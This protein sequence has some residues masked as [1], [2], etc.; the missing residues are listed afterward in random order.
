MI[1]YLLIVIMI[2]YG[3]FSED[4]HTRFV[5]RVIAYSYGCS[6]LIQTVWDAPLMLWASFFIF[7]LGILYAVV[8][9]R[10]FISRISFS[11][12]AFCISFN[13]TAL[14]LQDFSIIEYFPFYAEYSHKIIRESI[15]AGI[16]SFAIWEKGNKLGDAKLWLSVLW[17]MGVEYIYYN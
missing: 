1:P 16:A 15:L 8:R 2:M 12:A 10:N 5:A 4:I 13:A 17:L 9:S 3:E 6:Q 14:Y 7:V 11:F